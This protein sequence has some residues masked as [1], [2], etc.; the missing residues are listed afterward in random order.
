[1]KIRRD[2]KPAEKRK[3]KRSAAINLRGTP[4]FKEWLDGFAAAQ[5]VT[6]SALVEHGLVLLAEV[7]KYTPPPAR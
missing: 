2:S 1:M 7:R 4:D 5:R 6:P 3:V